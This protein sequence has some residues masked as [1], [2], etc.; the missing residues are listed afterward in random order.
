MTAAL[1]KALT[2]GHRVLEILLPY[3]RGDLV[4]RL[5]EETT[6]L[7]EE[8]QEDGIYFQLRC[9]AVWRGRLA[10]FML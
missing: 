1:T 9:D 10:E 6:I 7:D 8:Y 4:E 5:H 2:A 3:S